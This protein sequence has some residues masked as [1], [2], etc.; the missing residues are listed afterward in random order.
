MDRP[1]NT[2]I[3]LSSEAVIINAGSLFQ[4]PVVITTPGSRIKWSFTTKEYD[5]QFG[6][7]SQ[8]DQFSEDYLLRKEYFS[9][10]VEIKGCFIVTKPDVYYL[11]WDNSY[12]WLRAKTVVYSVSVEIPL[13]T[14]QEKQRGSV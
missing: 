14:F 7:A 6:I 5:C 10:D 1:R 9:P 8:R 3:R 12:S 2:T 11:V 13:P 4:L